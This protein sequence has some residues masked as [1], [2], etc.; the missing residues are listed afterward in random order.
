ME[1]LAEE[2]Q[3]GNLDFDVVI[4]APDA[5]RV[6]GRLGTVLG[7]RGLMPNPKVGTVSADVATAVSN[8]KSGQVRFRTDKAGVVHARVGSAEFS[9]EQIIENVK[10]F[11]AAVQKL[12]PASAK[13]VYLQK[14][15]VSSTMGPG[16]VLDV[17]S[18][19]VK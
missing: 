1:D 14:I 17:A 6:V 5:M 19:D 11:I 16:I 15:A 13:G 3:G 8:A 9:Q 7:P 12:K 4:A 10:H 2:I 18:L